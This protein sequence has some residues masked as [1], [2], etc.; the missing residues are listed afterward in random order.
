MPYKENRIEKM[1]ERKPLKNKLKVY[2]KINGGCQKEIAKEMG[3]TEQEFHNM[4]TGF[5]SSIP[6]KGIYNLEQFE[7]LI[8]KIL[9]VDSLEV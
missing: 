8:L 7:A 9:C 3:I 1:E 2:L 5:Q 6:S 4:L